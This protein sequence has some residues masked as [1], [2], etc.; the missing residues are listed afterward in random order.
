[1]YLTLREFFD[2]NLAENL[3]LE[4]VEHESTV[5]ENNL[6]CQSN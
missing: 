1:M 5:T 2:E 6:D 4:K 3:D